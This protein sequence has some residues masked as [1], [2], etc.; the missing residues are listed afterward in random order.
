MTEGRSC[1]QS[2]VTLKQHKTD[3]DLFTCE[4]FYLGDEKVTITGEIASYASSHLLNVRICW[5]QIQL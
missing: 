4:S 5:M 3:L 2:Y 1:I